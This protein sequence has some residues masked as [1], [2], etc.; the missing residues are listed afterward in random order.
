MQ[1]VDEDILNVTNTLNVDTINEFTGSSG[2]TIEGVQ[3]KDGRVGDPDTAQEGD[4]LIDDGTS[5]VRLPIGSNGNVLTVSN[6]QPAWT[7][8]QLN[9]N[10][11]VVITP[12]FRDVLTYNGTQ[13]V[14]DTIPN[15]MPYI[16][17]W[18]ELPAGTQGQIP[19]AI[20]TW[21]ALDFN[22]V[23]GT[24]GAPDITFNGTDQITLVS[25][26]YTI[27]GSFPAFRTQN[28]KVRFRNVTDGTDTLMG[29]AD[30]ANN[31]QASIRVS[32][33]GDFTIA[34]S[35]M[36]EVQQIAQAL[37]AGNARY[38]R[39]SG[40]ATPEVYGQIQIIKRS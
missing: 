22:M 6:D 10:T 5:T 11:D 26:T 27:W 16:N 18:R 15:I 29:S 40:F 2:V 39:P 28:T 3:I 35:K 1:N 33:I 12:T 19:T 13:W 21:E 38:G 9:N 24:L 8:Y 7:P 37:E 20:N 4:M 32:L 30:Y 23:S 14:D 25:G 36:F 34:S 17:I 31:N